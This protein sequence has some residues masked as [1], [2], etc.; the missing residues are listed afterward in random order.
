VRVWTEDLGA[1]RTEWRGKV[2]YVMS[3]ELR[4]FRD[5][6]NLITILQEML[7][8]LEEAAQDT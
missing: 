6:S 2:K 7:A 4:Y 1:G 5:W 8:E 3:G